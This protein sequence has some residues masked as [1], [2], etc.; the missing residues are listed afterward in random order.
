MIMDPSDPSVDLHISQLF[1]EGTVRTTW[2]QAHPHGH[3]SLAER[4]IPAAEKGP[5][6]VHAHQPSTQQPLNDLTQGL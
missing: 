4:L 1:R 6:E 5:Q 3:L 2:P